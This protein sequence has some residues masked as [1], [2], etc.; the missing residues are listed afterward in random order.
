MALHAPIY[1]VIFAFLCAMQSACFGSKMGLKSPHSHRRILRHSRLE[2]FSYPQSNYGC[3]NAI[4]DRNL[5]IPYIQ[6]K[7][8]HNIFYTSGWTIPQIG[9]LV[10]FFGKFWSNLAK[11]WKSSLFVCYFIARHSDF[12]THFDHFDWN[13]WNQWFGPQK[14]T[15]FSS[16]FTF[17]V[18]FN[19]SPGVPRVLT[20]TP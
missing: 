11:K 19:F 17:L 12:M 9:I 10:I 6:G 14:I 8:G 3:N 1:D 4:S 15:F 7:L 13:Q 2:W 18:I 16:F 5:Y 20:K